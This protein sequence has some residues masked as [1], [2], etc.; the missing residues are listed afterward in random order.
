MKIRDLIRFRSDLFFEGAVQLLWSDNKVDRANEAASSFVFHGPRYHGVGKDTGADESYRLTDTATL[1]VDLLERISTETAG[2]TNP[3]SLAIAGYGSGKSH[4]ALALTQLLR[5]PASEV[6]QKVLD[7]LSLAEPALKERAVKAVE[8]ISK[9]ALVIALDGTGNFNLGNAVSAAIFKAL[10]LG[11]IDD[12]P[13]R[14][15]SPRFDDAANFVKRNYQLRA[16]E[17]Q[18]LFGTNAADEIVALLN[19]RDE[20]TY[21]LVDQVYAQANGSRIPVEGRESAQDLI[22]VFCD[23]YCSDK[24]PFSKLVIVFDEFG[25][26]LEYV[27]ERPALAGDSALQQIFQG[28]QDNATR[29]HFVGFIQ[30]ELKAYLARMGSRDAMHIQKY[31]TRFDVSKKYYLSS[32]LETIIAHLVDKSNAQLLDSQFDK[33]KN[34]T[35]EL[36]AMMSAFLPGFQRLPVW[37]DITQFEQVIVRGC[38]PLHPMA[39]W[40]LTR[41]Q[42]IVQ[43]RSA[44]T[45]VKA[46]IDFAADHQA[47]NDDGLA[48][49]P[50]SR[51]VAGD[52]LTEMLAAERAHG[53]VTVD[54]LV[55]TLS[56]YEA[57]LGEVD[58]SLL[59]AVTATKK[60][61]ITAS[62]RSDYDRLLAEFSGVTADAFEKSVSRLELELGILAWSKELRQYEIVTDAATRGQYQKDFR[63]KLLAVTDEVARE[64]FVGRTKAWTEDLFQD[65]STPFAIEA[66]IPTSE[67]SFVSQLATD[68]TVIGAI[69]NAFSDWRNARRP[70]QAKGQVVYCLALA[71]VDVVQLQSQIN[72]V[73]FRQ[74]KHSG[75]DKAPVW[76]ILLSDRTKRI[77]QYLTSL[78]IFDEGFESN[79]KERYARFIPEDRET[80]KQG[81]RSVLK[82]AIQDR[83]SIY[84]GV[85]VGSG[86]LTTVANSIFKQVYSQALPFPFDGFSTRNGNGGADV[87]TIARS[88]FGREVSAAWLNVQHV[89]VQNRVRT[90]LGTA[91]GVLGQ[92]GKVRPI[93]ENDRVRGLLDSL[94]ELHKANPTRTLGDDVDMLLRPPYGCSLASASLLLS[95]F[96][97]KAI[98]PRAIQFDNQGTSL[99][100]WL[101]SAYGANS[102]YPEENALRKTTIVFLT[103]DAVARWQLFLQ[104]WEAEI[105][106]EGLVDRLDEAEEMR[107]HDPL[108]E[109]LE[110]NFKYLCDKAKAASQ[111]L[112]SHVQIMEECERRLENALKA[113]RA[114]DFLAVADKYLARQRQMTGDPKL[115]TADQ[116]EEVESNLKQLVGV[117][118]ECISNWVTMQACNSPQQVSDFRSRMDRAER[119]L[120]ALGLTQFAQRASAHTQKMIAQVEERYRY[121]TTLAEASDLLHTPDPLATTRI[122]EVSDRI[123][124]AERLINV[125]NEA[126]SSIEEADD[127]KGLIE[128]LRAKQTSWRQFR[129]ARQNEYLKLFDSVPSTTREAQDLLQRLTILRQQFADTNS[130]GELQTLF[131]SCSEIIHLF[132]ELD[133]VIGSRDEV[134][135]LLRSVYLSM[136]YAVDA[137]VEEDDSSGD[138]GELDVDWIRRAFEAYVSA[139]IASL[140]ARSSSWIAAALEEIKALRSN[141]KRLLKEDGL[142]RI[143]T[144]PV[145]LSDKAKTDFQNELAEIQCLRASLLEQ[146]R[147]GRANSWLTSMESKIDDVKALTKEQCVRFLTELNDYPEYVQPSEVDRLSPLRTRVE[148]RLDEID[149]TDLL[150]RIE[151][152]PADRR[153]LLVKQLMERYHAAA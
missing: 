120:K 36:H 78:Y 50:A 89:R 29:A 137:S 66:S 144:L 147:L 115:W 60:M 24:G 53:G 82:D 6:S 150:L 125:I 71:D 94:E 8:K 76:V 142:A 113:N 134:E 44:I 31:I 7:N 98:P 133:K 1:A 136:P 122:R 153:H 90:V 148:R 3:F 28:V 114:G 14:E 26:F 57:Q 146:E 138:E 25:R 135:S 37:N 19:R 87:A 104:E 149:V 52:L 54:N 86:R 32:N 107:E 151:A 48:V 27:A 111:E 42:D 112:D 35:Q 131:A 47:I 18:S 65:I 59:I 143:S 140:E 73:I 99:Q 39:T 102:R 129:V 62:E 21:D 93:P 84:A 96:V 72:A 63:K 106:L 67:W 101:R 145:F 5:Q 105:T 92:D 46:A 103:A 12:Q 38:W 119:T 43:S 51:I 109:S 34:K 15:L 123:E 141:P 95:L 69:E 30:Y 81:L 116:V 126:A 45:F 108:P 16:T 97:G 49:I 121:R 127:L 23:A 110:P 152:M 61:R 11:G 68:K 100:E 139:Q 132:E 117:I 13:L 75:A 85:E 64:V 77:Q 88:L 79:E 40:F 17:F 41:Q 22:T 4:F 130:A 118:R 128:G 20:D 2:N 55:A 80:A 83:L 56:K 124:K 10:Q 58:R 91:W 74:L 9:P 70:D 33:R